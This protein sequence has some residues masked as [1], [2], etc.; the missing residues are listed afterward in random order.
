MPF[1]DPDWLGEKSF[2]A[3]GGLDFDDILFALAPA[4]WLGASL[5]LL[6]GAVLGGPA[7]VV[8]LWRRL[9]R[10]DGGRGSRGRAPSNER[11]APR[12]NVA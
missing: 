7:V 2:P 10:L 3:C 1:D 4:L 9:S 8:V 5:P 6:L 12:S 11:Q